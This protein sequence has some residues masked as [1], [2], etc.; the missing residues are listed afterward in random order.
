MSLRPGHRCRGANMK[1][2]TIKGYKKTVKT[3][4]CIRVIEELRRR[5]YTVGSSKDTHF[6]GFAMDQENTD[7]WRHAR[8]GAST[9]IIS[10][11]RETDVLYQRRVEV[12]D[13]L[14]LFEEDYVVTEGDTG[15]PIANI[16]TGKTIEDLE[17]RRDENT[18]GFSGII[19]GGQTEA[20]EIAEY[21]GLPVIDAVSDIER[22]VDLI[23]ERSTKL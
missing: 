16:V 11:P 20:G 10:G 18:V 17:K 23:E 7:S 14:D 5:G 21:D 9:V 15:L 3:T 13:L 19:A 6:E 12:R 22:L 8:A 4:T 2:I 1:I